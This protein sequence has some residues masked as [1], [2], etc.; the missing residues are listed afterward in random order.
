MKTSSII[1]F[2]VGAVGFAEAMPR[3]RVL[4][5]RTFDRRSDMYADW[6][7]YDALP[8]DPSYPTKA[9]WGVWG[10]E[11]ELGALNHITNDTVRV[12]SAEIKLG[13]AIPLNL[14]LD[15]GPPPNPNRKPLQHLFQPGDGYTDDVVVMNTQVSTQFDGLRHFPYS[16]NNS[17]AT[18]QWYND[19]IPDYEDVI[20]P[21]P[22]T[23]L[24]MQVPA[25]KGIAVR[26]VLFDWAGWMDSQGRPIDAFSTTSITTDDLD[27]VARWQGLP[28][29]WSLPG[30]MLII[31]TG[32]VRQYQT[33]NHTEEVL[34]PISA[35]N[36]VGME[37]S[38]ASLRWLWEKKLSLVGADNPAFESVRCHLLRIA[39]H[40][41]ERN[42]LTLTSDPL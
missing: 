37:A 20:G 36:W 25:Q 26:G 22:S 23:V 39:A 3:D 35:G 13:L 11:D 41:Y 17:V 15:F 21:A 27:A 42:V 2:A 31:R 40:P 38:E 32:W 34:L 12:A 16:T 14:Q 5:S 7:S 30:D 19:L 1:K 9:A 33:L 29:D 6:P 28:T 8:L 4:V 24:G 18:Y 10:T